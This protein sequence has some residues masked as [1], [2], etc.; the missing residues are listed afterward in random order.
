MMALKNVLVVTDFSEGSDAAVDEGRRLAELF[1]ARLHLLHVV[2]EPFSEAWMGYAPAADFLDLMSQF[3]DDARRRLEGLA[4]PE[5]L[6]GH[7]VV[8]TARGDASHEILKYAAERGIDLVVCGTDGRSGWDRVMMGSV[9]ERLVRLAPCPV[10]TVHAAP[11]T[12]AA[13]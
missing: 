10:L 1:G 12:A 6:K 7:V 3:E 9:A 8:A 2:A 5:S 13:A 11:G 4:Q